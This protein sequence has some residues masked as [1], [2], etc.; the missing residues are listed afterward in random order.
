MITETR[1]NLLTA[2]VEA[3]VNTVNCVGAMGKGI[4][5]QFKQAFPDNF[6]A[7]EKACRAVDEADTFLARH[8][9]SRQRLDRVSELN[10]GF[11]TPY[12][13]ELLSSV[14]WVATH[15]RPA[16]CDEACVAQAVQNWNARK[17]RMFQAHHVQVAWERLTQQGWLQPSC[18]DRTERRA[19][20]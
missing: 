5:L 7:Y 1:G 8:L 9:E 17:R 6:R 10:G 18:A 14:H 20:T 15:D 3:L 11:E 19:P 2:D 4:A 16:A 13:M 12:G